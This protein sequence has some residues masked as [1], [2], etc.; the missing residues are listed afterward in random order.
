MS[1]ESWLDRKCFVCFDCDANCM[2]CFSKAA[3]Q[4]W[5]QAYLPAC[6]PAQRSEQR[7]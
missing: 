2:H 4:G 3:T 7:R 6:R 5:A 1:E